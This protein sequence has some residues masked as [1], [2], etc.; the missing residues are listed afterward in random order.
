MIKK[1]FPNKQF[2]SVIPMWKKGGTIKQVCDINIEMTEDHL[3]NAL[4]PDPVNWITKP[5]KRH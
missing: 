5:A 1:N 3:R 4:L 2:V